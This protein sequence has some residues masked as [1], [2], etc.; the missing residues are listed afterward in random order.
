VRYIDYRIEAPEIV[1]NAYTAYVYK[2]LSVQ[3]EQEVRAIIYT[4]GDETGEVGLSVTVNVSTLVRH[5]HVAP[6]APE[7][8]VDVVRRAAERYGLEAPVTR[9]DLYAGPVV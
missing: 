4:H 3:H 8:Y 5:V 2:R 7:W 6:R 1:G 9:S